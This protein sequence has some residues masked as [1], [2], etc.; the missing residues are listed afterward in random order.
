MSK[1][2]KESEDSEKIEKKIGEESSSEKE[3]EKT[4]SEKV[5]EK[6]SSEKVEEKSS[7]EKVE[8][9]IEPEAPKAKFTFKCTK[10]DNCCLSRGPI[11]ITMWDLGLWARNGVIANFMPYLEVYSKPDG[12]FD[13]ILKPLTPPKKDDDKA[14]SDPFM[15]TPIE[16]LLE[17]KC[18][19]YNKE[20][21]KCLIYD[22]R[23]LS[24]RTYPLEYDGK[25]FSVVNVDCPGVGEPGMSKEELKEMRETA[26]TMFYELTRMRIALPVLNQ[27]ISKNVMMELMRQNME[28]MS[29]ISDE[30]REKLDDIF[31][32]GQDQGQQG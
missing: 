7:S 31:K 11:P 16:E 12:G 20:Q 23:P 32:K 26:K 5:E 4:S 17:E 25:N 10:C 9:K 13:L 30:D 1:N 28:A 6:S 18:P 24:C 29:K 27:I 3:E 22:N 14:Q 8:E 21:K 15:G 2:E 19:L